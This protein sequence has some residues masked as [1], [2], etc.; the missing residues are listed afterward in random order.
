[1][2]PRFLKTIHCVYRR[3]RSGTGL[4]AVL[5]QKN[6]EGKEGV[7]AYASRSLNQAEKNYAITDQECLAIV[8]AIKHFQHYLGLKPFVVVT[9][10]SALKW[11][12]TSKMPTGRR[13]RWMMFL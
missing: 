3:F 10:H 13:A 4:E 12:Q 2:L 1:M 9:D 5:S 8:W 6:D 7:I 11:L